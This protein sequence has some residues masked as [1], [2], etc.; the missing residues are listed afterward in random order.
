L[1]LQRGFDHQYGLYGAL[2]SY[3]G[4]VRGTT[5]D[6]HRNGE[7]VRD[8]GYT[9]DLIAREFERLME[10]RQ[11]DRPFFYYVPFNA[12]H[13]T[14]E[15]PDELIEKYRRLLGSRE[16]NSRNGKPDQT[17]DKLAT[18]EAMDLAI[19][20]MI[21]AMKTKG[22]LDNTLIVFFN[23]NGGVIENPPFRGHKGHTYEGGVRVPCIVH[24]P[25][26]I[27]ADKRIDGMVHAVDLYPTLL[28]R[29]G[30]ALE[31]PLPLDGIDIW[32]VFTGAVPSP[33]TE[34]VHSLPGK[35]TDTGVMSIRQGPWKLVG[36]EL[37]NLTRDPG[38]QTDVA[39]RHPEIYE[40]LH[41]RIKELVSERR[42]PEQH[43]HIPDKPLLVFG[44][45][46]NA[47]PPQWL[48]PYLDAL[49]E[50]PKAIRKAQK[51]TS[52]KKK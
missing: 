2:I 9:T 21:A 46:E 50:S 47:H 3:Y 45:H 7:T 23:D 32:D 11:T 38:E 51:K 44:Q 48:K 30:G 27:P 37:Y 43:D 13:G 22:V 17:V 15:A 41:A 40:R 25:G 24:W 39:A 8:D 33:R 16:Q 31:Q 28:K 10:E 42:T 6:W 29:A 36:K 18:L 34:V 14:C 49:P 12:I 52:R 5:Y 26:H 19:G 35:D 1:P 4:K 20:R